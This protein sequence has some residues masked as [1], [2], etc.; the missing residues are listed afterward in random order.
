MGALPATHP[1]EPGPGATA[2]ASLF[3]FWA[4]RTFIFKPVVYDPA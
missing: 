2:L 3:R 4:Y 1:L